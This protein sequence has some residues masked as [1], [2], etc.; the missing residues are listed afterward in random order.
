MFIPTHVM[1]PSRCFLWLGASFPPCADWGTQT[2]GLW[3][4]INWGWSFSYTSS[5]PEEE[6][7]EKAL[8]L[9]RAVAH[10][11]MARTRPWPHL[12]AEGEGRCSLCLVS[13]SPAPI[14]EKEQEFQWSACYLCPP[15]SWVW[16]DG[17]MTRV[18]PFRGI[19]Y[20]RRWAP[21]QDPKAGIFS[22]KLSVSCFPADKACSHI[23]S[24]LIPTTTV[25]WVNYFLS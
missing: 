14:W 25:R 4:S 5:Q 3:L 22:N 17:S 11:P 1:A 7:K 20:Y 19:D 8:L 24:H 13:H 10:I 9:C 16:W 15:S 23:L 12:D 18:T 6:S 21:P 2:L